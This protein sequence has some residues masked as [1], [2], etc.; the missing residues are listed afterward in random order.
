MVPGLLFP[1][2]PAQAG[3]AW[4]VSLALF[5]ITNHAFD[6]S[7]CW[8]IEKAYDWSFVNSFSLTSAWRLS[9]TKENNNSSKRTRS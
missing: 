5:H 3:L 7:N 1:L 2:P 4:R 8:I 6:Y 9:D